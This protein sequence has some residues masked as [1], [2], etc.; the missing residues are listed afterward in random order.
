MLETV[1][2]SSTP[3]LAQGWHYL[4]CNHERLYS[5]QLYLNSN[6]NMTQMLSRQTLRPP[7]A[8]FF[9]V[10]VKENDV[11]SIEVRRFNDNATVQNSDDGIEGSK[12]LEFDVGEAEGETD[13][14]EVRL[15]ATPS[16]VVFLLVS[17]GKQGHQGQ[18]RFGEAAKSCW[19]IATMSKLDCRFIKKLE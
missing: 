3:G 18:L 19:D 8:V 10:E 14:F 13:S 1:L 5:E 16:R 4:I 9:K 11:P 7:G 17:E 2:H 15:T 6:G 12:T